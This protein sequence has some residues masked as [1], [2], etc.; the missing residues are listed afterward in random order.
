MGEGRRCIYKDWLRAWFIAWA[1]CCWRLGLRSVYNRERRRLGG[2]HSLFGW[3]IDL[4]AMKVWNYG[5]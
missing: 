3:R 1:L 4:F 2:Y 5:Q